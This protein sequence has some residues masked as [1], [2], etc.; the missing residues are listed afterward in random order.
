MNRIGFHLK[1]DFQERAT[2]VS[3]SRAESLGLLQFSLNPAEI[4]KMLLHMEKEM[5]GGNE[6]VSKML[7][8][9]GVTYEN[10]ENLIRLV[11]NPEALGIDAFTKNLSLTFQ[12]LGIPLEESFFKNEISFASLGYLK[13][14]DLSEHPIF[15][16]KL[17]D[18]LVFQRQIGRLDRFLSENPRFFKNPRIVVK[19]FKAF[20]VDIHE[21]RHH[22]SNA[23]ELA[24]KYGTVNILK[25]S[26]LL[27]FICSEPRSFRKVSQFLFSHP[28]YLGELSS[29]PLS[30]RLRTEVQRLQK[31]LA[32][33]IKMAAATVSENEFEAHF[34]SFFSKNTL[35]TISFVE[36]NEIFRKTLLVSLE[37]YIDLNP[38][39]SV[40][41]I[42]LQII[43]RGSEDDL[44]RAN[45]GE[46]R[47]IF[48]RLIPYIIQSCPDDRLLEYRAKIEKLQGRGISGGE[49]Q[50]L[51]DQGLRIRSQNAEKIHPERLS[52]RSLL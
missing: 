11:D 26:Q 2:N 51:I 14:S 22:P 17:I 39:K 42:L 52:C 30:R 1:E 40:F 31:H 3:A 33:S 45:E 46:I 25:N 10:F 15:F 28:E 21:V 23:L 43:P 37:H 5:L 8:M 16:E 44:A 19:F 9:I 34:K 6:V 7:S 49:I 4:I 48:E 20:F 18:V 38:R 13:C 50:I 32:K 27:D 41:D 47:Q 12:S 24:L 29:S 35:D 36:R